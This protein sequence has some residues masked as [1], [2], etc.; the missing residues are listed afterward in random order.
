VEEPGVA[1]H[2]E[3]LK[4]GVDLTGGGRLVDGESVADDGR[5]VD[6]LSVIEA[7]PTAGEGEQGVDE[8]RLVVAR[9]DCLLAGDSEAVD[10]DVRFGE[11][12]LEDRLTMM[13]MVRSDRRTRPAAGRS[14][15]C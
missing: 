3:R 6:G 8:L 15:C 5:E 4:G 9:I 7:A 11:R 14:D 12:D 10:G 13:V 2:L 1:R